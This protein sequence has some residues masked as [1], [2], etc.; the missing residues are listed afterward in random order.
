MKEDEN[1][2]RRGGTGYLDEI[3]PEIMALLSTEPFLDYMREFGYEPQMEPVTPFDIARLDP[4]RGHEAFT[5]GVRLS[6][7]FRGLLTMLPDLI[8]WPRPWRV[9]NGE[10][11]FSWL[12]APEHPEAQ[13]TNLMRLIYSVRD[14]LRNAYPDIVASPREFQVWFLTFA[15]KEYDFEPAFLAPARAL[16]A[17]PT[18]EARGIVPETLLF[19]SAEATTTEA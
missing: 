11:L 6:P 16:M 14:D 12:N 7:K 18:E 3:T 10:C 8:S 4:F 2:Y 17:A 19:W 5:N 13:L 1:F 9:S 15:S